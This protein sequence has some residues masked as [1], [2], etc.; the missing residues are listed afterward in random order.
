MQRRK[1]FA[2]ELGAVWAA[3][4]DQPPPHMLDAAII[5]APVSPL[6]PAA[7]RTV[8]QGGMVVCAGIY[9][10]PIP[11]FPYDILWG[12]RAVRSVANL[13]RS[14]GEEFLSLAPTVPVKTRPLQYP[15][16]QANQAL[17]DLRA[18]VAYREPRCCGST[19]PRVDAF[20]C[21]A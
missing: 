9:M 18:P 20:M 7:L 17:D 15:L 2:R 12:E 3:G 5:F 19:L 16:E 14:D 21:H 10:S 1:S 13:T 6:E 4:S 8:E 11:S